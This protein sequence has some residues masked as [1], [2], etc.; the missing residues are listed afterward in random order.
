MSL[1]PKDATSSDVAYSMLKLNW[2]MDAEV[3]KLIA[4]GDV[5]QVRQ[6]V[7]D[8]SQFRATYQDSPRTFWEDDMLYFLGTAP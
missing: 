5:D 2:D 4:Q 8:G 3:S 6:Q 1:R 7:G